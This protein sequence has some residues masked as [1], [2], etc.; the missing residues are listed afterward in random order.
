DPI[1]T[2]CLIDLKQKIFVKRI[3]RKRPSFKIA[4]TRPSVLFL[5]IKL[6]QLV[7]DLLSHRL[8]IGIAN[9]LNEITLSPKVTFV[10]FWGLRLGR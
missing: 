1:F 9:C 5:A 8:F 4:P 2:E 6:N 10:Y 7:L 3:S